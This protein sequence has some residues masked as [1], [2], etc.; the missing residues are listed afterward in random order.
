MRKRLKRKKRACG[1]CKPHKRGKSNRWKTKE[2]DKLQRAEKE[3]QEV[4]RA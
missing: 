1:L 3:I 2:F 4:V